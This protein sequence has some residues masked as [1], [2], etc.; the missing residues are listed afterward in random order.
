VRVRRGGAR[1]LLLVVATLVAANTPGEPWAL[2]AWAQ[3][4]GGDENLHWKPNTGE[5]RP[6]D[7]TGPQVCAECH[8]ATFQT[9]KTTGMA[10]ATMRPAESGLLRQHPTLSLEQGPYTYSITNEG[11]QVLFSVSD[12]QGRI[13]EPVVLVVGA[14]AIHQNYLIQHHGDYYQVPV[15]YYSALGKIL[16]VGS[17][18]SAAP[19]SLEAALGAR[20]TTD[21]TRL[22]LQ[23]HSTTSVFGDQVDTDYMVP[24]IT[25]EACHGPGGK[26]VAAMKAGKFRDSLIFDP[27]RLKPDETVDFCGTCHHGVQEVKSGE[28]RGI[29]TVLSQPYRLIGSRCWNPNDA[30][31][32]CT[33]C[34]NPHQPL[35]RET[36]AYDAKCLSCHV[37]SASAPSRAVQ[38]GKACP[39][40]K[41]DCAG[42]HMPKV[43]VPGSHS[44][45]TDHRIRI[46]HAGAPYPE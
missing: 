25:C 38:P 28:L 24:G 27:G 6:A 14:G 7:Y 17:A 4:A 30:R 16:L 36:A 32:R 3:S 39:V 18:A 42:C 46:V 8:E 26:H 10:Q 45:F 41:Q 22:C 37:S 29:R 35:V 9:Q 44:S 12:S 11:G 43:E 5:A 31:S 2:R 21:R 23:C 19:M 34:H 33:S 13:T 40:G 15:S 20:L 1:F